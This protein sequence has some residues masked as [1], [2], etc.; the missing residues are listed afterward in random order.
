M[1]L[2]SQLRI[3]I[4]TVVTFLVIAQSV[5]SLRIA[6][7]DKF[8]D[9][10]D[11]SQ[12]IAEQVRF[13]VLQR[14]NEQARLVRD[15]PATMED[16]KHLWH[17]LV[18][19]DVALPDLLLKTAANASAVIEIMVCDDSGV[20]LASS[21][22]QR[23]RLTY[24]SLPDLSI[25][26]KRPLWDRLTD[27]L[28]RS[29]SKDY[30][31]VQPIGVIGQPRPILNIRV[32]VSSLLVRSSILPHVRSLA[33]ASLLSLLAAIVLAY[34]FSNVVLRSLDR[35][36]QR[37]ASITAGMDAASPKPPPGKEAKEIADMQSK[38][39]VL[40]QQFRGARD[41]MVQLRSNI[42]RMLQRLEE[43]FLLFDPDGRLMRASPS[44]ERLL[45]DS[46]EQL[47]GR[48]INELFPSPNPLGKLIEACAA[49]N[50]PVR[51]AQVTMDR[52]AAGPL[53]LLVNVEP[54]EGFPEP[55]RTSI[56][57]TLRDAETRRQLRSQL[58]ISTRLA[59]ISRL[60]G[61]VAHEIKN[62]L[63]AMALHLEILKSKL[64][65]DDR[66]ERELSV[67]GGEI[68]R[69]DRVVKTFLDFT[70]P[71]ELA[72]KD[73]NMV[74]LARQVAA[75]VWPDA[76]RLGVSVELEAAQPAAIIRGDEDL[77][78]QA[79]LNVVNN[80]ME[81]MPSGGRL[82]IAVERDGDEILVSVTDHGTGIPPELREK[83]F[84][85]YFTTKKAGSGIG[86]AMTFRVIQL[87]NATMDF[88]SAPG[89]GTTFRMRFPVAEQASAQRPASGKPAG[90][91]AEPVSKGVA[92]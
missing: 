47:E 15:P 20:I 44:V 72:F 83:I 39:D 87:H 22:P 26:Q 12:S 27:V 67:I 69:L 29:Q 32:V 16:L 10:L 4:V 11:R 8:G 62:P 81:A 91:M 45:A 68:S 1:S 5:V 77:I 42:E 89:L 75:L 76:E 38:L 65:G 88:T 14:V 54:L 55:G 19:E 57:L 85:L 70:R 7:E 71:V 63:N 58:D 86:L 9:A 78:K 17:R 37:I 59:A 2:K 53:R 25:W 61:G 21:L 40:S 64:N 84:N 28:F 66:V 49:D 34:L 46:V 82:R 79:L 80:G 74:E 48:H 6:A 90:A 73:I 33:A 60:T 56:L 18:E 3:A 43:G 23:Q 92:S 51:D 41:D 31:I 50:S 13:L 24:E 35:L 36:S 30:A 52:G